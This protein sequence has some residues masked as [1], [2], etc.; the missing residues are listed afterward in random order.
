M[1]FNGTIDKDGK[2]ILANR[3]ML[4]DWAKQNKGKKIKAVFTISLRKR[5][6]PQNAYY[7]STVI[8][9]MTNWFRGAGYDYDKQD[10]HET[11][12]AMFNTE[13][14]VN[15]ATGEYVKV[16]KSTTRNTTVEMMEYIDK[17]VRWAAVFCSVV[18]PEPNQQLGVFEEA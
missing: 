13:L 15:P 1:D 12:K 11:L 18:I 17:I 14:I 7:W 8:E 5:T 9:Y 3:K 16:P 6:N 4:A 10:T 2:I